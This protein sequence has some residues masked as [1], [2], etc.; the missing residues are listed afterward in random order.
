[1]RGPDRGAG[2]A[3]VTRL[4]AATVLLAGA[5]GACGDGDGGADAPNTPSEAVAAYIQAQR[6]G[7]GERICQLYSEAY[8]D[9]I[10]R[11]GGSCE[12]EA[13]ALSVRWREEKRELLDIEEAGAGRAIA[14]ISCEDST[15]PDCSLPLV[16]ED[17]GWKVDSGLHPNDEEAVDFTTE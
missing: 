12:D 15:A 17:G 2:R 6:A 5:L 8:L 3:A 13:A 16:E 7:D 11:E 10:D 1:V 14:T 9:L 4:A